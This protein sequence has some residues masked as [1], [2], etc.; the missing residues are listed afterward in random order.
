M[1][2]TG[3]A[4]REGLDR[5]GGKRT[6]RPQNPGMNRVR[7]IANNWA[8]LESA[9][10]GTGRAPQK[11]GK[12]THALRIRPFLGSASGDKQNGGRPSASGG[13]GSKRHTECP[14][15]YGKTRGR[16]DAADQ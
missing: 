5:G 1:S 11:G 4:A 14:S 15:N 7:K 13:G 6:R 8:S 9:S 2:T 12:E 3:V 16:C 10:K